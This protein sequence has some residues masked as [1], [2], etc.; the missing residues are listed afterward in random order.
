MNIYTKYL[1]KMLAYRI[2]QQYIKG[3]KHHDQMVFI[4]GMQGW[5]NI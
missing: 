5:Y 4:V 1:N 3:S 2:Q